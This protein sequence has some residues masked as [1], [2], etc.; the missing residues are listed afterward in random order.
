[1]CTTTKFFGNIA[2]GYH[3]YILFIFFT[4]QSHRAGFLCF[5]HVHNIGYNRN[6][7]CDCIIYHGFYLR[8]FF[9]SHSLEMREVKTQSVCAYHG[10]SLFHMAAQYGSQCCLQQM[11]CTVVFSSICTVSCTYRSSY[12]II[13]RK[14]AF[15]YNTNMTYFAAF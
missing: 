15:G 14:H 1:M 2:H 6:C 3:T 13:Y 4:E 5:F 7:L 11:S 9:C 8:D 12:H 10:T